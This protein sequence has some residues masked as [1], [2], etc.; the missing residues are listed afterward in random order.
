MNLSIRDY[1]MLPIL[2]FIIVN[3]VQG[4]WCGNVTF[5]KT[6]VL[7]GDEAAPGQFPFLAALIYKPKNKFFCGGTLI[8]SKHVLTG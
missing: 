8:T 3:H 7:S 4:Q 5:I 6:T 1:L 2:L